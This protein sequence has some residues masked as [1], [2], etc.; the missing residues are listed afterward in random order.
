M[1]NPPAVARIGLLHYVGNGDAFVDTND[2]V[3]FK[4]GMERIGYHEGKNVEYLQRFGNRSFPLTEQ[5][6]RE[7]VDWKPDV[8]VS[9]M[10]NGNLALAPLVAGTRIPVVAWAT[11]L[12]AAGLIESYQRPGRNFTGFSYIPYNNWTKVRLVKMVLPHI[13]KVGHLYNHT[14]S[15]AE[16]AMIQFREAAE[17]MGM[18]FRI[19]ETM[20]LDAFEGSIDAMK[21]DGCEAAIVGPHEL[22]NTNGARLGELFLK[23]KLPAVGN[24][25]S[26]ARNGGLA[27]FN[28][29]KKQAWPMM[30]FVVDDILKG[31]DPAEIPIDRNCRGPFT[32]NLKAAREMGLTIPAHVLEEADVVLT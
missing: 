12:M 2:M 5:Y 8:I 6:A 24:Q 31:A 19:Y 30:A 9:F 22:F 15:P 23:A 26:I 10:T 28:P 25:L 1:S 21:R 29:G 3:N 17:A 7:I 20:T 14:Y 11:D 16:A 13:R 4:A 27:S 18:E 32:L